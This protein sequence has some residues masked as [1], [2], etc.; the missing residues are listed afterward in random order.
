[1]A[2]LISQPCITILTTLKS[3]DATGGDTMTEKLS[4]RNRITKMNHVLFT[5]VN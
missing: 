3:K 4:D 1:M 5:G 2:V